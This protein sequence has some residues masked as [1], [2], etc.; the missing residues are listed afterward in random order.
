MNASEDMFELWL[1]G[2][3]P[4]TAHLYGH[5]VRKLLQ[6]AEISPQHAVE[7]VK[8]DIQTYVNLKNL[9]N[10]FTP[11]ARHTAIFGLRRF[12]YD[13]GVLQLPPAKTPTPAATRQEATL[14]WQ[15]AN[16]IIG[17][18]RRPYNLILKLMLQCGLGI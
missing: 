4:A 7:Q 3:P 10:N 18:A 17:A 8:A 14:T 12:L 9:A 2:L 15:E 16:A 13:N 11:H 6:A 5:Y 1:K